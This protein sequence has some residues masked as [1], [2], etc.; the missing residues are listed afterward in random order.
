MR[1]EQRQGPGEEEAA[2][3]SATVEARTKPIAVS[4]RDQNSHRLASVPPLAART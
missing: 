4:L 2:G 3:R 1:C